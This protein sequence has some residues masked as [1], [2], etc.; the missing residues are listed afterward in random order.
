MVSV[1]YL[2]STSAPQYALRLVL[3]APFLSRSLLIAYLFDLVKCVYSTYRADNALL[4]TAEIESRE[5][6]GTKRRIIIVEISCHK[7]LL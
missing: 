5:F 4:A 7:H 6:L 3:C 1:T 2:P